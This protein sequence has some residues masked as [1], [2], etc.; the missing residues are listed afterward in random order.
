MRT[1]EALELLESDIW[2]V[3]RDAI[4]S[5]EIVRV[6]QAAARIAADRPNVMPVNA[7]AELLADAALAAGLA[8]EIEG[9]RLGTLG[10]HSNEHAL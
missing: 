6:M 9:L 3:V 1:D 2:N 5:G 10:L 8:I 4:R 7:I